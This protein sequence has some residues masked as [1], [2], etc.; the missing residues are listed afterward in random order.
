MQG[1]L[2]GKTKSGSGYSE[3]HFGAGEAS[4]IRMV[5]EIELADEQSMVLIEEI[6]NGRHP[7]ATV[8]MVE[9]LIDAAERK[10]IQAIFTSHSNDAIRSLPSKAIWVAISDKIFQGKLDIQ[11]LRAITGQ[12]RAIGGLR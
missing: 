10:K 1:L 5:A 8:R 2:T 12:I 4:V 9:Y 3:F 7:V 11:S 6:E